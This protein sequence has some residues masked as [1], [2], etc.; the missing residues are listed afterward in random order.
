MCVGG[1]L[2][3]GQCPH[4]PPT[5]PPGALAPEGISTRPWVELYVQALLFWPG[6]RTQWACRR[7]SRESPQGLAIQAVA[8]HS[9]TRNVSL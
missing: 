8:D 6:M 7:L 5:A 9:R 1:L 2:S 4:P 3:P